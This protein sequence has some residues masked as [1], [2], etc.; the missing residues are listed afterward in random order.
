[1]KK[2]HKIVTL[3]VSALLFGGAVIAQDA[4]VTTPVTAPVTPVPSPKPTPPP[5]VN[6]GTWNVQLMTRSE[7]RH[8]YQALA[9]TNQSYALPTSQ[10]ARIGYNYKAEKFK[11]GVAIQDVRVWGNRANLPVDT[12]GGL[13]LFEGWGELLFSDKASFKFGRQA[14][15]YD[16]DRIL[17]SLDWAMQGRRHDVGLFKYS[18]DSVLTAHVG[19]AY[20]QDRDYLKTNVYTVKNN[21]K[22]M[23]FV[24][25]FRQFKTFNISALFLNN[26]VQFS[27][28]AGGKTDNY[29]SYSQTAGLRSLIKKGKFQSIVFGY[30]QGGHDGNSRNK[31]GDPKRLLAYDVSAEA[32]Y[33]VHKNVGLTAGAEFLSGTTQNGSIVPGSNFSFNPLYGTNHRFNGYMDYFYVGNHVNSVGLQDIYFKINSDFNKIFASVNTHLFSAMAAVKDSKNST[34]TDFVKLNS[35]LGTEI[36]FTCGYNFTDGIGIQGGY[37]QMFGT[38]TLV[39]LKGGNTSQNSNWAYL[40]VIIRPNIAKFPKTGLKP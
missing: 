39:A 35:S 20:N 5:A 3:S 31:N 12:S 17:G 4:P 21:Y 7:Y 23:Q 14:L 13:S 2:L 19:I 10:R 27:K 38:N 36:D 34:A 9:D 22:A 1:M 24:W 11:L 25:L 26:G 40:M 18:D 16:D 29:I 37:S 32:S 15:S 33:K 6:S 8:G 28:V 30:Y